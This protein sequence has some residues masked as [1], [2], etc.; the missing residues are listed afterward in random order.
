MAEPNVTESMIAQAMMKV[1]GQANNLMNNVPAQAQQASFMP[2]PAPQ[3]QVQQMG[4]L[5]NPE[6]WSVPVETDM[7]GVI[8]TVYVQFPAH[9]FPQYQQIIATMI[10]MGYNVRSHQKNN[11]Y[12]GN[13][14]GSWGN[15][16]GGYGGGYSR[17]GYGRGGYGRG[18]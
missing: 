5:P 13:S 17:G 1:M 16:G 15:R 4:G 18:Y 8:V 2:A 3:Q 12:G 11:G 9:T 7:G 10:N 6:G 14:G